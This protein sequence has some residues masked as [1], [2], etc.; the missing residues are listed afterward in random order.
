[1][2]QFGIALPQGLV[3]GEDKVIVHVGRHANILYILLA[4]YVHL[5]LRGTIANDMELLVLTTYR[6]RL[7]QKHLLITIVV[8]CF[9]LQLIVPFLFLDCVI[10]VIEHPVA[11]LADATLYKLLLIKLEHFH[12]I[13][14]QGTLAFD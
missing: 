6:N 5:L 4:L 10:V 11:R 12:L 3:L 8:D 13:V 1:M 9:N 14:C 7:L 2:G